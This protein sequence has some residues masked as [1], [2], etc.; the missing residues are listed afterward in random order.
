M[1][2]DKALQVGVSSWR[3]VGCTPE[4]VGVKG[5]VRAATLGAILDVN[6][7]PGSFGATI[8]DSRRARRM[9]ELWSS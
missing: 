4:V 3:E 1:G 9:A 5:A 2:R 7:E 6:R 8:Q